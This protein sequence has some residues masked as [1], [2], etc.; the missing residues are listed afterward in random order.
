MQA[1]SRGVQ[2][3]ASDMYKGVPINITE[4]RSVL[5]VAL[6][7][8]QY[9]NW[10]AEK[11]G[12]PKPEFLCNG[13]DVTPDVDAVLKHIKEF[14]D[15]VIEMIVWTFPRVGVSYIIGF[16]IN[17]LEQVFVTGNMQ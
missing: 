7:N 14:T 4:N 17:K 11:Q 12:L 6:R 10:N 5:H 15:E 13:K 1:K 8:R 9:A 16:F 2:E 3:A